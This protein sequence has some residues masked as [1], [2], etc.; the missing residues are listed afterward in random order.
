MDPWLLLLPGKV[1]ADEDEEEEDD[2]GD[3]EARVEVDA[4]S[5]TREAIIRRTR[6]PATCRR[7]AIA[8]VSGCWQLVV[9]VRYVGQR[10]EVILRAGERER[11]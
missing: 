3:E 9:R 5:R 10:G 4:C 7:T 11:E 1:G 2:D 6:R 8:R